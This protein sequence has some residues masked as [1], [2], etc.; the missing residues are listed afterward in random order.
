LGPTL[1]KLPKTQKFTLGGRIQKEAL[2]I[3]EALIATYT[4]DRQ[5]LRASV[6][7]QVVCPLKRV[8]A[9]WSRTQQRR[10]RWG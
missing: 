7:T 1:Q 6:F 4:P 2:D 3:L 8:A 9:A 5:T 10:G